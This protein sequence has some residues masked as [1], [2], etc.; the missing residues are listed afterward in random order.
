[1][2]TDS[3]S[4]VTLGGSLSGQSTST[5]VLKHQ[6]LEAAQRREAEHAEEIAE[7]R[8]AEVEKRRREEEDRKRREAEELAAK[9]EKASKYAALTAPAQKRMGDNDA[10]PYANSPTDDS[11]SGG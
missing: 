6:G 9:V 4:A 1:M 5:A 3:T 11:T 8:A 10:G 2:P 7:R